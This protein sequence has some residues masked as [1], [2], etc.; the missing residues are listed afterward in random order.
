M[1]LKAV[2]LAHLPQVGGKAAQLGELIAAALPVPSGFVLTTQ[3]WNQF[4]ESDPRIASWLQTAENCPHEEPDVLR[5]AVAELR[6]RLEQVPVPEDVAGAIAAV[7]TGQPDI[8]R[9]VRGG[10]LAGSVICRSA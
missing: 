1:P 8:P 2:R 3:A 7:M 4:V 10:G 6:R 9:A 5:T